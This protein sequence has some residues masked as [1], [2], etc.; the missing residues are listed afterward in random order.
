MGSR[1]CMEN[2][3]KVSWQT[4]MPCSMLV[5]YEVWYVLVELGFVFK[6]SLQSPLSS[7]ACCRLEESDTAFK[8]WCNDPSAAAKLVALNSCGTRLCVWECGTKLWMCD[9]IYFCISISCFVCY[10][11]YSSRS[12]SCHSAP[13][14]QPIC[15]C[16]VLSLLVQHRLEFMRCHTVVF[17]LIIFNLS[18]QHSQ[19]KPWQFERTLN[20]ADQADGSSWA[21]W[22]MTVCHGMAL[23]LQQTD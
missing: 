17:L 10:I 6:M 8:I 21:L 2:P 7:L 13:P 15:S 22:N 11:W 3:P 14:T 19:K 23:L 4:C 5:K 18:R 1:P 16:K 12:E 9:N 20:A